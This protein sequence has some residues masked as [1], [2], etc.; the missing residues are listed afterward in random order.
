MTEKKVSSEKLFQYP[1]ATPE[2]RL[3]WEILFLFV[4]IITVS[5]FGRLASTNVIYTIIITIVFVINLI[6]RFALLNE[7]GDWL[8]FLL[9][10]LADGGNYLMSMIN[11]IYSYTSLTILPFLNGLLPLWMIL[12]WGQVFLIFQ[13][14]LF[15]SFH[16]Y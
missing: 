9:G 14:I 3:I 11:G 5:I 8:F 16:S 15:F 2:Q 6:I 4:I 1:P 7:K 13:K 12:F 10:V